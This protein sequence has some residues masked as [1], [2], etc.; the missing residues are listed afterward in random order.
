MKENIQKVYLFDTS[1]SFDRVGQ[2]ILMKNPNSM[3]FKKTI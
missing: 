1:K 3:L 2:D